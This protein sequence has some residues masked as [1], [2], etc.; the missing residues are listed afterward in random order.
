MRRALKILLGLLLAGALALALLPWWAGWALR[1]LA[2]GQHVT[3][4]RYERVGYARFRLHGVRREDPG[5][6]STAARVELDTPLVW[7]W[8][9]WRSADNAVSVEDWKVEV[10]RTAATRPPE[11][12]APAGAVASHATTKNV[13]ALLAR[14]LPQADLHRGEIRIAG[15]AP[16]TIAEIA[17]RRGAFAARGFA[18][19]GHGGDFAG[20]TNDAGEIEPR[21]TS[22]ADATRLDLAWSGADL[23][24]SATWREQ[25]LRFSA[26]FS[27]HGWIPTDAEIVAENWTVPAA[28]ARMDDQYARLTGGGKL[29]WH[30]AKFEL[31]GEAHAAPK[32]GSK[33]PAMQA[34]FAARGD[35][36]AVTITAF[37]V[38]A[39]FAEAKLSAPVTLGFAGPLQ[40][41]PAKLTL[42]ADLAK[43]AWFAAT[44]VV[45]GSVE[46]T[47]ASGQPRA[48]FNLTCDG[49]RLFGQE[50]R[51]AT[52]QGSLQ[53]PRLELQQLEVAFDGQSRLSAQGSLDLAT[54]TFADVALRGSF[55]PAWFQRWLP[56]ELGWE[57]AA[58]DVTLSGPLD[59]P[60]HQGTAKLTRVLHPPFQP[61][62]ATLAWRGRGDV[63][64]DITATFTA[65][66]SMLH[67]A[68]AATAHDA[69]L[70]ELRLT[71]DGTERLALVAPV[72]LAW[73]PTWRVGELRLAGADA[74]VA[75]AVGDD[76]E[77]A[78]TFSASNLT[79]TW[80]RDWIAT[81][82]PAWTVRSLS[83]TG[84]IEGGTLRFTLDLA[85]QFALEPHPAQFSLAARGD[86]G[87]VDLTRLEVRDDRG[88]LAQAHGR[89]P[90]S[91]SA[92][93]T[94]RLRLDPGGA[95][96]LEA[97]TQPDSPLWAAIA[98]PL[99]LELSAP[100]AQL[101]IAGTPGKPTGTLE[102]DVVR[103]AMADPSR[104]TWL[105]ALDHLRVRAHADRGTVTFDSL[106]AAVEG[107]TMNASA[108]WPMDSARWAQLAHVPAT[109]D[110]SDAE[111]ELDIPGADLRPLAEGRPGF[112][113]A[114]GRLQ[115]SAKLAR[116]IQLSGSLKL[117]DAVTRPVPSL[118][119]LQELAA[120]LELKGREVE[121][122][123]FSARLG[124]EAVTLSGSADLAA[125]AAPKLDL[126]LAGKNLPLVR[127][128]GLLIRSDLALA[129]VTGAGGAT[130]ITGAVTLRDSLVLADLRQ[131]IPSGVRAAE[132][133]PPYFAV[134]AAPFRDWRLDVEVRGPRGVRLHTPVLTGVASP[135]FHLGGTLGEP[136]AVGEVALD[137]GKILF[138]FAAFDVRL[139]VVRL[140]QAD[141][142]HP[143]LQLAATARRYGYDL[144]LDGRGPVDQPI[145]TLSSNPA[146][147]AE[148]VLLLVMAGQMPGDNAGAPGGNGDRKRLTVLGAYLGRGLFRGLGVD[149]PE[150][151]TITSGEQVTQQGGE[152]YAVEYKLGARWAL[153]GEYDEFDDY[154]VGLKWRAYSEGGP[155]E[156]K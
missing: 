34:R 146:L 74:S 95:L 90:V 2:R 121:V 118:G 56:A 138:P 145:L 48:A 18:F 109:F 125:P 88:L 132:Q 123:S 24:G 22:P 107:Q 108:R 92:R 128:A 10:T 66:A 1:P 25:P 131:F 36:S 106:A 152:T 30:D 64:D 50:L 124:G 32:E 47:E 79:S 35:R 84:R 150:R 136:R 93:R 81:T 143:Q 70:R 8:R 142:F 61:L 86:A 63:V 115:V 133:A 94:P 102:L 55:T 129:A 31:S 27:A 28:S 19:G 49:L 23:R 87:G 58:L 110:W 147:A 44:G 135:R 77:R 91:W 53:W 13:L 26:K 46:V 156:K 29:V 75:A 113:L 151:L 68:G 51:R 149:D 96:Q 65:G 52:A 97:T 67:L 76:P 120:D 99:G 6:V 45:E 41:P 103:I 39:P 21:A 105:P 112:P 101:R 117:T 57:T 78:F 73:S 14:W 69:Q 82:A 83:A 11:S 89:V 42:R 60:I 144:R 98:T 12:P 7:A 4:E 33:A 122:R 59:G 134:E 137:S 15:L 17:W 9:T 126:K 3:F 38:N 111:A 62:D 116:G 85:A 140:S 127:K 80:A 20:R 154:N 119:V 71:Q 148:E 153:I 141:P 104:K 5:L 16:V 43:Q 100:N 54:R 155:D 130:R 139:A 72:A 114:Q 40:T 37:D